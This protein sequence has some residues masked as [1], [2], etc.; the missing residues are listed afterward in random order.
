MLV[1]V[2]IS[3][4]LIII[5]VDKGIAFGDSDVGSL[6]AMSFPLTFLSTPREEVARNIQVTISRDIHDDFGAAHK[7]TRKENDMGPVD[8]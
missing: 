4:N 7:G 3:F 5:R 2:G 6:S 8:R 1:V